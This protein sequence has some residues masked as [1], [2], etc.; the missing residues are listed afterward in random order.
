MFGAINR[1]G[2]RRAVTIS[3]AAILATAGVLASGMTAA[4]A[5]T[6]VTLKYPVTGTTH[7]ATPNGDVPL[8]PGHLV[9]TADLNTDAITA[10]LTLPPATGSFKE[11]GL[12]PVTAT[13]KL[14]NDGPTTGTVNGSTGAVTTTSLITMQI[15]SLTVAGIPQPVGTSCETSSPVS[16][17]VN[18]QP[19]F[20]ILKGGNLSGTYTIPDFANCGLETLLINLTVPGSGN[21]IT[22]TLGKGKFVK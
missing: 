12:I 10:K 19:G 15:T 4:S 2:I 16:V 11:L 5:D 13:V 9:S 3:A 1:S 14:I 8:G 18:S 20:S 17:T 21:T 22:L 6:I 7:L